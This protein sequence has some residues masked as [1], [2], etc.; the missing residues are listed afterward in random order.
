MPGSTGIHPCPHPGAL[1][2]S[3]V[4]AH[5]PGAILP[6]NRENQGRAQPGLIISQCKN[7]PVE[8]DEG[9]DYSEGEKRSFLPPA[10]PCCWERSG[11]APPAATELD[12]PAPRKHQTHLILYK[13]T[14]L[15]A[16]GSEEVAAVLSAHQQRGPSPAWP[17]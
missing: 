3:L 11:G 10:G 17:Q 12:N 7:V 5:R 15:F 9:L 1:P 4:M 8:A 16:S 13:E 2:V 6:R 14:S